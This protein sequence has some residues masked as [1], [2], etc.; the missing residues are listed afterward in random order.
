MPAGQRYNGRRQP[1]DRRSGAKRSASE[2]AEI[3]LRSVLTGCSDTAVMLGVPGTNV[4]AIELLQSCGFERTPSGFRM[5][6]G[7]RVAAGH[8]ECIFGIVNGAMG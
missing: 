2:A 8:P 3:L 7:D 6:Y 5:V 1:N 4:S